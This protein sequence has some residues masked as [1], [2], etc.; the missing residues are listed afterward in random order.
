VPTVV[1]SRTDAGFT[2]FGRLATP[3]MCNEAEPSS[4]TLRLAHLPPPASASR[5][6]PIRFGFGYMTFDQLS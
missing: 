5:V 3:I 1:A 4:R 6:A 2:S